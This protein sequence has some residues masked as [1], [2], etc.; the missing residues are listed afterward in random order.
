MASS[1]GGADTL[2]P[3]LDSVLAEAKRETT[4][5]QAVCAGITKISRTGVKE[6]WEQA[7]MARFPHLSLSQ[8]RIVPDYVIAF[9]GAIPLGVGIAVIAGT[10][11]VVYGEDSTGKSVRLG[12]RGWEYGD[13]GS[14]A[15]LTTEMIRRTLRVLDGLEKSTPLE[16]AVIA[17][18]GVSEAGAFGEQARQFAHEQG[19]GFLVPLARTLAEQEIPEAINLFVG[20]AGWLAAYTRACYN[21]L[22]LSPP[23]TIAPIG[24]LWEAGDLLHVPFQNVLSRWLPDVAIVP[25]SAP[26]VVGACRLAQR[27]VPLVGS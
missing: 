3:L 13:E 14:G 2:I 27:L 22:T 16:E 5:L 10:G 17:Q 21:Q 18:I 20:A 6:Q 7:L 19:R 11:S 9:H 4:D 8:C 12:G 24:G 25:P 1:E 26:P 15:F 23:V